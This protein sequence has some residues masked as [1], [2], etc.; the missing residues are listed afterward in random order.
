MGN[1]VASFLSDLGEVSAFYG[2]TSESAFERTVR[3]NCICALC[4]EN[5][6]EEKRSVLALARYHRRGFILR[7]EGV[8]DEAGDVDFKPFSTSLRCQNVSPNIS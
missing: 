8:A 5:A 1:Q 7:L 4:Q 3:Q 2:Y 6:R